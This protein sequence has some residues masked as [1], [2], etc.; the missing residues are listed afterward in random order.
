MQRRRTARTGWILD[1]INLF[2]QNHDPRSVDMERR[3]PGGLTREEAD[4]IVQQW[5]HLLQMLQQ[6][7]EAVQHL[8]RGY[9]RL[10]QCVATVARGETPCGKWFIQAKRG[11]YCGPTC[12]GREM[13]RRFRKK[14]MREDG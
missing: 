5:V 1:A 12:A 11:K 3:Y 13:V 6:G 14:R 4:A 8:M 2:H 7:D 10:R 9:T